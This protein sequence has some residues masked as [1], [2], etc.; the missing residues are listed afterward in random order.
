MDPLTLDDPGLVAVADG[1]EYRLMRPPDEVEAKAMRAVLP[2][3][4]LGVDRPA[5][6]YV[7]D[8]SESN[9]TSVE[10]GIRKALIE[11]A[12]N[13]RLAMQT[14]KG[15]KGWNAQGDQAQADATTAIDASFATLPSA[16]PT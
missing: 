6:L 9:R 1:H 8:L 16:I 2:E 12:D 10:D 5:A 14:L 3:G 4:R 7:A 11:A 15:G 13:R